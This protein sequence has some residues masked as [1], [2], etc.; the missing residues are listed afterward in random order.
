VAAAG[1]VESGG[2]MGL[3]RCGGLVADFAGGRWGRW[4]WRGVLIGVGQLVVRRLVE[5]GGSA[6]FAA[7]AVR[8]Y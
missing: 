8:L 5:S 1:V 6:F 4:I 2:G 7:A 3:G